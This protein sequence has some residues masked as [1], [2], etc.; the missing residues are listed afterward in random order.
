[1]GVDL[2]NARVGISLADTELA[3]AQPLTNITVVADSFEA[4]DD[5]A[6]LIESHGVSTVVVGLPLQMNGSDGKAAKKARRWASQ[7]ERRVK[8]T[9]RVVLHDERLTT[10]TAHRQ[11]L[12][13][14]RGS[15]SHRS[16]VD[17]QAAV[18]ILQS[19]LDARKAGL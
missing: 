14:G 4:L 16:V 10:V 11:L 2:G 19:A 9:A 17:Q 13:A 1:M 18:I 5:V 3:M 7:L 15:K 12:E 8:E 6:D